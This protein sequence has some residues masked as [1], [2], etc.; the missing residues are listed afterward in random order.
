MPTGN[1][2][3]AWLEEHEAVLRFAFDDRLK[4][5]LRAIP[6]RRW[7]PLDR[8]WR[9][10]LTPESAE[11]VAGW[12]AELGPAA[13]IAPELEAALAAQ[14][15]ARDP[16]ECLIELVRFDENRWLTF[17]ADVPGEPVA[18]M[19]AHPRTVTLRT[20]GRV[21]VPLDEDTAELA[22]TACLDHACAWLS[23]LGRA[24]RGRTPG[25]QCERPERGPAA[26][27]DPAHRCVGRPRG[28]R[29]G[30]RAQR[31]SRRLAARARRAEPGRL[32][33]AAERGQLGPGHAV[34]ARADDARRGALRGRA[35]ARGDSPR[36]RARAL[37][38]PRR[39]DLRLRAGV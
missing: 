34:R 9:V 35:R 7:E 20:L 38:G 26:R 13:R 2:A 11:S 3:M 18:S 16:G 4:T 15:A 28:P 8:V 10:P 29:A 33:T 31:H 6:G 17:C 24:S 22:R 23:T 30:V 1:L 39:S 27:G 21:L 25:A 12:L 36:R 32:D 19:L 5:L 37:D 14:R